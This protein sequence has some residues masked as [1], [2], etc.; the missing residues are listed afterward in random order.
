MPPS[1][2]PNVTITINGRPL[3]L[4]PF[5]TTIVANL[6]DAL[7]DSLH[8]EGEIKQVVITRER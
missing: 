5:A 8:T 4:N 1:A 6:V 7:I 2:P 3:E